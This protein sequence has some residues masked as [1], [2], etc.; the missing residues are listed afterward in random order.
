MP[1]DCDCSDDCDCG[2]DHGNPFGNLS[3]EVQGKIQELQMLE[4]SFQQLLRQKSAFS[5]EANET[6]YIIAEVEKTSGE[7][8]RIVGGQVII[9]SSKEEI[10]ED[11]NNKKKL[12]DNR[13]QAIDKEEKEFSE[14]IDSLRDEVMKAIQN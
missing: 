5:M 8:S 4:Q 1:E 7:V 10:L 3:P 12:I 6:D 14:K 11:M 9:K 13:M 2:H